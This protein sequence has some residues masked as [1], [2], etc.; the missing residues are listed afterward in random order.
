MKGNAR[1]IKGFLES[2]PLLPEDPGDLP[3]RVVDEPAYERDEFWNVEQVIVMDGVVIHR[4]NFSA[5]RRST[6]LKGATI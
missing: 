2:G 5:I 6:R 4:V 1:A 3:A